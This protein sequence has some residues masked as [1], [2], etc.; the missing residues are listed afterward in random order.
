MTLD[1]KLLEVENTNGQEG[2]VVIAPNITE[3]PRADVVAVTFDTG[4]APQV[5]ATDLRAAML[6]KQG[7]PFVPGISCRATATASRNTTRA[8][9]S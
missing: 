9:A 7:V 5:P 4:D 6:L 3:G 2:G 1:Q 8:W